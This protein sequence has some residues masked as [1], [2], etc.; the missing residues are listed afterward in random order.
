MSVLYNCVLGNRDAVSKVR[1]GYRSM[2]VSAD[3]AQT[4][5]WA[6]L[7]GVWRRFETGVRGGLWRRRRNRQS[8]CGGRGQVLNMLKKIYF[9]S[10]LQLQTPEQSLSDCSCV[11]VQVEELDAVELTFD[12]LIQH[13]ITI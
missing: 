4:L 2:R 12:L 5:L 11:A 8:R 7:V 10:A 1:T 13:V 6:K 3:S 9:F